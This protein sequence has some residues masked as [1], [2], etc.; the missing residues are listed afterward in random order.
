MLNIDDMILTM[1]LRVILCTPYTDDP[2]MD[3]RAI[4]C[5]LYAKDLAVY[6]CAILPRPYTDDLTADL[7]ETHPGLSR[8]HK[9]NHADPKEQ[10]KT[11]H[12]D[13]MKNKYV[14]PESQR[15]SLAQ[16]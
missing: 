7:K 10:D 11:E 8:R 9:S 2:A 14:D 6:V 12:V 3:I 4:L 1:D 15:S 5:T 13:R 16:L